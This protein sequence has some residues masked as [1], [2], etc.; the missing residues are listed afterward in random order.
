MCVS[1][2]V[3]VKHNDNKSNVT[4][5]NFTYPN[6]SLQQYEEKWD[7]QNLLIKKDYTFQSF[8]SYFINLPLLILALLYITILY[9]VYKLKTI[10][11]YLYYV[12]YN[13]LLIRNNV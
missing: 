5:Y 6:E 7:G 10:E 8:T 11:H 12:K 9:V 3:A 13:T 4:Q 1:L 2:P